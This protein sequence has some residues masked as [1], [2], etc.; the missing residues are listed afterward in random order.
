M[1]ADY[2]KIIKINMNTERSNKLREMNNEYVFKVDKKANKHTIKSAVE[3]LFKV[4][5]QNVRTMIMPGKIRRMGRNEGKTSTWKKAIVKLKAGE[6]ISM[7]D[8]A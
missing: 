2:R 8:N 4:K 1:K 5:V 3:E 7:F 6:V